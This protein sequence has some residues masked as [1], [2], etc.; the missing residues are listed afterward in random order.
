M[1]DE[2]VE[3]FSKAWA[4]TEKA[5]EGPKPGS[6]VVYKDEDGII[7]MVDHSTGFHAIM[8]DDCYEALLKYKELPP[9]KQYEQPK[10]RVYKNVKPYYR[11]ERW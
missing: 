10:E 4:A 5:F 2:L 1:T 3:L 7:H 8:G 11:K 9:A 6:T